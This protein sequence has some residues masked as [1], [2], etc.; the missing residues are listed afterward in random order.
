MVKKKKKKKKKKFSYI[1][2]C[3]NNVHVTAVVCL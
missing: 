3:D 2:W 1:W